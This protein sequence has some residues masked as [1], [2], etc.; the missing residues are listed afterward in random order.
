MCLP[1]ALLKRTVLAP[2]TGSGAS[3]RCRELS[4]GATSSTAASGTKHVGPRARGALRHMP[5]RGLELRDR[6]YGTV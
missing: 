6:T 4:L 3:L 5:A 2:T 1:E